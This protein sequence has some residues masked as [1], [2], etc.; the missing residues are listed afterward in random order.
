MAKGRHRASAETIANRSKPSG[1][2]KRARDKRVR[3][4]N[5]QLKLAGLVDRLL[6]KL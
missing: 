4:Q 2:N 5:R 6:S 1:N 3:K